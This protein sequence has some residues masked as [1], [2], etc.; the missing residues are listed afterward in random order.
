[1]EAP[2]AAAA[3]PAAAPLPSPLAQLAEKRA[4]EAAAHARHLAAMQRMHPPPPPLLPLPARRRSARGGKKVAA[5][6]R[7]DDG[8]ADKASFAVLLAASPV[9]A[10]T[11]GGGAPAPA[12]VV[13][14]VS[15]GAAA[16][17]A[18]DVRRV[19]TAA[20][21]S[22]AAAVLDARPPP[23]QPLGPD[24]LPDDAD[25]SPV[26]WAALTRSAEAADWDP[27]SDPNVGGNPA[28]T[29]IVARLK[30]TTTEGMLR[31]AMQV[32]GP[33]ERLRLVRHAETQ[34][35]MKYAF[36]TFRRPAEAAAAVAAA[37][38][39]PGS[40]V[41]DG[42]GGGKK[43]PAQRGVWVDG[44]AVLVDFE[45]ARLQ[46]AAPPPLDPAHVPH[47][48]RSGHKRSKDPAR[49]KRAARKRRLAMMAGPPAA[50]TDA[51][52]GFKP[53]RLRPEPTVS[54]LS[55]IFSRKPRRAD[56]AADD[57]DAAPAS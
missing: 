50:V 31:A 47:P 11:A 23:A 26:A 32:F 21:P 51:D 49:A 19:A 38:G 7:C 2:G 34:R 12:R 24:E 36:V 6:G 43:A 25:F 44:K 41:A 57:T 20:A 46:H 56:T 1:M 45:R 16:A 54:A 30:S 42:G 52:G 22:P 40:S 33:V 9:A 14:G 35:S 29:V 48:A 55:L 18:A 4:A 27:H 37:C 10:A 8:R 39:G 28:A 3:A 17:A 53:R 5:R 13:S 15:F